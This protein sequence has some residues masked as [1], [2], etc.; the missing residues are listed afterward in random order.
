MP[1]EF[2][3]LCLPP[4]SGAP[5]FCTGFTLFLDLSLILFSLSSMVVG[6]CL[7]RLWQKY[8]SPSFKRSSSRSG[9]VF[10][11]VFAV[12]AMVGV[13]GA[14]MNTIMRGPVKTMS[15]VTKRTIAENNMI[16]GA[17]LSLMS[18]ATMQPDSGD[19]DADGFVEP[20]PFRDPGSAPH[21][22]GGGYIPSS[23]GAALSDPWQSEYGYCVWDHG[24]VTVSDNNAGCGGSGAK[25]LN[26]A[27]NDT[28][29]ALVIISAGKD[30]TFQT[31]CNAFVDANS[32]GIPDTPLVN[33]PAGSDDIL[34]GH[35]YAEANTAIGGLWN[36]KSGEPGT[37]TI[38][39]GI[40]ISGDAS[41]GGSLKLSGGLLLP[42]Q[43]S[44]GACIEA[45]DQQ[46]RRN[47]STNPPS[48]EIC[49][50]DGGAGDWT[51]ISGAG[52][53]EAAEP[54]PGF[55][56]LSDAGKNADFGGLAGANALCLTKLKSTDWM[57]KSSAT[58][59]SK[60][61]KAFLCTDEVTD[62]SM[63]GDLKPNE[64]YS[65]AVMGAPGA[66][67]AKFT[68]DGTGRGPGDSAN[69]SGGTY[70]GG[71]YTY[72]SNRKTTGTATL[73]PNDAG[74]I[75]SCVDWTS[76]SGAQWGGVGT[77]NNT[78]ANRWTGSSPACNSTTPRYICVVH[79]DDGTSSNDCTY[80]GGVEVGGACWFKG[81]VN[82]SCAAVCSAAGGTYNAATLS[83][84]G[85]GGDAA[86]C[87][88]VIEALSMGGS[89]APGNVAAAYGCGRNESSGAR[90]RGTN[91]TTDVAANAQ[92]HRACACNP[93]A[94]P[95]Q[96]NAPDLATV[97]AKGNAANGLSIT[98]LA[99]PTANDHAATKLY[100]DGKVAK[101]GDTMTGALAMS[102]QKITGLGTPTGNDDAARKIDI[103]GKFGALANDKWCKSDGTK[104][105]CDQDVPSALPPCAAGL[106][107]VSTGSGWKCESKWAQISTAPQHSCGI[108]IG[109]AAYC[110]GNGAGGKLG[111]GGMGSSNT[112][113]PVAGGHTWT[114]IS[115][116]NAHSCGVTA[117]GDAYCWGNGAY[118]QIGDGYT[119]QRNSPALVAGGRTWSS[120]S[121]GTNHSCG[122]TTTGVGY[123]WGYDGNGT[124][125][126]DGYLADKSSPVA[127]SGSYTW[128]QISAGDQHTCG[129]TTSNV[130]Y[131]W[132]RIDG[133]RLGQGGGSGN[134][135]TP[136]LISGSYAWSRVSAGITHSCGVTTIG[137]GYCWGIGGFGKLG[138][139]DTATALTPSAVSGG[140]T[141]TQIEAGTSNHTCGVTNIG[142]GYCWG[143]NNYGQLGNGSTLTTWVPS[144]VSGFQQW[145]HII[146]AT[147][148]S[149]GLATSGVGYCWGSGQFGNGSPSTSS[150]IPTPV[151]TP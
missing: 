106:S 35:T 49:D 150:T 98:G 102:N 36:L 143:Y 111:N 79:P 9:N 96:G 31:T 142:V 75:L 113:T 151:S 123:C 82:E 34:L 22:A 84:A 46:L 130:G 38:D 104:I 91:A 33:K 21:P 26:G 144:A 39:K 100:A 116:G 109:G 18:A 19:C 87:Q 80:A 99:A 27:P 24:S 50:W 138:N 2:E 149:C 103:D 112:P 4:G 67:G 81:D 76:T 83:Y 71:N 124:L 136:T 51:Q 119:V 1:E 43:T 139:N 42:D 122:V 117:T 93:P 62:P 10:F 20:I 65:F 140:H 68:T 63:C 61:V 120:V 29:Y 8:K 57:G 85:S 73:W 41:F 16:A 134:F 86:K 132:G 110:W 55:F 101:T 89:G 69:W 12:V 126:D 47:T 30:R 105:V 15:E 40:E 70:F 37:A 11:A 128:R 17:R 28:Q 59:N 32:D 141:W 145:A 72:W 52:G 14:S 137:V 92:I 44:S 53:G 78:N 125:G 74:G 108:L 45:N 54:T 118:G 60:T 58:L 127:I 94:M 129:V 25:R 121:V 64:E 148:H 114:Q 147:S 95:Y 66:G 3:T 48:L 5:L 13:V 107:I 7:L 135:P 115:T 77:S 131:C 97:L 90:V 6:A 133:G 146:P 23:I 56:V 88:S